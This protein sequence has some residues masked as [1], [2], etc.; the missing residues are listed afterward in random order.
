[1]KV[2]GPAY[3]PPRSG[4]VQQ[5]IEVATEGKRFAAFDEDGLNAF[6]RGLLGVKAEILQI[7]VRDDVSRQ[8]QVCSWRG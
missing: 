6:L 8:R 3:G 2:K 4:L 1:M 5:P 7:N